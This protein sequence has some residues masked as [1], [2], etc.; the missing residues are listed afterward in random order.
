[1]S[2]ACTVHKV[3]GLG[4]DEGVVSFDLEKQKSFNQGQLCVA[5]SRISSMNK[6]YSIGSYNKAALKVNELAKKEY[7]RLKSEGLFKSQSHLPVTE[8]SVT[9]TLL[10]T[11][12]LKLH[13]LNIAMDDRLL[14]NDILCL[15]ETQCEAGCYTSVIESALQKKCIMQFNN[16]NNKFKSIAYGLSND[17]EILATEYFN[18]FLTLENNILVIIPFELLK[19]CIGQWH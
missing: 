18:K 15:T 6:M 7:E 5:L 1:M 8:T 4:L 10:N 3:Q 11:C 16:S 12:S 19:L 2:W 17:V 9:I 13:V 14:D